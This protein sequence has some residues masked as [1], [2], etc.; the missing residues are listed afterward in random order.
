M[1]L[2]ESKD[3]V[4]RKYLYKD[5]AHV[6]SSNNPTV[7][8]NKF[9][10]EAYELYSSRQLSESLEAYNRECKRVDELTEEVDKKN[11]RIQELEKE[12]AQWRKGPH[13]TPDGAQSY[14]R[15]ANERADKIAELEGLLKEIK[16]IVFGHSVAAPAIAQ[17]KTKL[18]SLNL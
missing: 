18:E 1:T 15:C 5:F 7:T 11:L 8:V 10:E 2:Q 9:L 17:L 14:I 13:L 16:G 6:I 4:A 3:E 12:L